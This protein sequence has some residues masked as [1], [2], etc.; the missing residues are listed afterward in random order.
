M[1]CPS[2]WW[3]ARAVR[4]VICPDIS[5]HEQRQCLLGT[6]WSSWIKVE[7]GQLVEGMQVCATPGGQFER[8]EQNGITYWRFRADVGRLVK[9]YRLYQ[10]SKKCSMTLLP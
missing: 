8:M 5:S 10:P 9:M 2:P 7:D 4:Q 6:D 3:K 1:S